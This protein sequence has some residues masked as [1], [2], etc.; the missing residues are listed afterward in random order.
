MPFGFLPSAAMLVGLAVA[1]PFGYAFL[2]PGDVRSAP[3]FV[4]TIVAAVIF[5]ALALYW[6]AMPLRGIG[7]SG[8]VSPTGAV[9]SFARLEEH[10]SKRFYF[11]AGAVL[12][13]QFAVCWVTRAVFSRV[14][15]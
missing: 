9:D 12:L 5:G 15:P 3:F 7:I 13:V 4:V 2:W 14:A 10:L 1:V 6:S 11:A 8:P